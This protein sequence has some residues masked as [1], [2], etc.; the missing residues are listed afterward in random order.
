MKQLVFLIIALVVI[1]CNQSNTEASIQKANE[2]AT[3]KKLTLDETTDSE[4]NKQLAEALE[5]DKYGMK[6]YVMA[7]LKKGPNRDLDSTAAVELQ[8]AHMNNI[9]RLAKEG[10]LVLAGPFIDDGDVRGIYIFDVKTIAE[11]KKLTET[12][13]AIK[14]GSLTM[15]LRPWYGSAALLKINE[16]HKT[17]AEKGM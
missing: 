16:I 14:A 1:S 8:K 11:A 7:F 9:S 17:I 2:D 3:E 5:A 6:Q 13:P 12:D 10:K 15:E 4:F